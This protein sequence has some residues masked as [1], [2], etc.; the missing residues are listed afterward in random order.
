VHPVGSYCTDISQCTF[1]KTLKMVEH[2]HA[3]MVSPMGIAVTFN[4]QSYFHT[5]GT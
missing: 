2:V 3:N 1:N 5:V 4:A